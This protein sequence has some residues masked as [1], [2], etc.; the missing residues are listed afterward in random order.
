M[1]NK[2]K[3]AIA[4]ASA[5][6]FGALTTT[7]VLAEEKDPASEIEV[8]QVTGISS[9]LAKAIQQKRY[10]D[11]I[12]DS[13]VAEDLGKMP[14][15]NVAESLQRITGV[16]ISR[17]N[18]EG[19]KITI[20][21]FGPQFNVI[22]MNDRTLATTGGS[23][24]FDFQVLPSEMISGADVIKSPTA[25]L[26]SG[27]IGGYVNLHSARPLKNEGF[28]A[29]GSIKAVYQDLAE[30]IKPEISGIVSNTFADDTV[31]VLLGVSYKDTVSRLDTYK[32]NN[33][34]EYSN[35]NISG[36]DTWG[37]GFPLDKS[38]VLDENG[39]PTTLEG[40]RG[41]GRA[42]FTSGNEE[43]ERLG[44]NLALQWAPNDSMMST[45][46]MLYAKL[47]REQLGS[48]LQIAMQTPKYSAASVSDVG[49]LRTATLNNTDVEFLLDYSL[50]ES[51]TQA[52]G[53]NFSYNNE[54][55]TVKADFSYSKAK[56]SSEG[57]DSS[58]LHYTSFN[59]DGS[60]KKT[61]TTLDFTQ[62]DIPSLEINGMDVTDP[63]I[64]RAAWQRY[65]GYE[66]ED[67]IKEVKLDA[68]Y[69]FDEGVVSSIEVGVAY[70]NRNLASQA[71]GTEFDPVSGG[72]TWDGAG[73]WIG[74][75]STWGTDSNVGL[76]DT[77]IFSLNEGGYMKGV[78]GNFPRQWLT[79][80]SHQAYR[81]ASQN[82]L[83]SILSTD[84]YR[85]D[86]V[87]AGWDTTYKASGGLSSEESTKSAYIQ[88]NLGGDLGDYSWSGNIGGRYVSTTNK[89]SGTTTTI[90]LLK[91]QQL[92]P[93][94]NTA[95]ITTA[96][97]TAESSD[98]HFL[99]SANFSFE[100]DEGTYIRL[101]MAKNITRP[102]L[103]DSANNSGESPGFS[104]PTVSI[105]G[106]N[107]ELKPYKVQQLDLSFEH[108]GE[109]TSYA[110]GYFYKNI[111][112]FISQLTKI[113]T[114]E[115]SVDPALSN[116][117]AAEGINAITYTSNRKENREGGTIQGVE[118]GAMH[119]FDYLSGFWSGFGIQANYTWADSED[120]D[121]IEIDLPGIVQPS[122]ALEGFA[123]KSYNLVG[124][125]DKDGIGVRLAYNYRGD[126]M[127]SRS[128]QGYDTDYG[129]LDFSSSYDINDNV[130]V[131]F[132]ATNLTNET[133]VQYYGQRDR[134]TYVELSGVRYVLGVRASF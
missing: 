18:G 12:Q 116:A 75:G 128:V 130:A 129:Q 104:T 79:V 87:N 10:A 49:T 20:R 98:D 69:E 84:A 120:K 66:A 52:F 29:A 11:S 95:D 90:D 35:Y 92:N 115:G 125:Y 81:E 5:L 51:T 123:E 43:R 17:V 65:R 113:G 59:P 34:N 114:W 24:D 19:S 121:Q 67:E 15:Q 37:Y 105:W 100:I 14:D 31:G 70:S 6:T 2:S 7:S 76:I 112:N 57:D 122:N 94:K 96:P 97:T 4:I 91:L 62:G 109:H 38:K 53:Y 71:Y 132:E 133:R 32:A 9:G 127:N 86:I 47:D 45:F 99:P 101:G 54:N 77:S 63:S 85:A 55:L 27:S 61:S 28:H 119:T 44:V 68:Q 74:D 64:V 102:N 73:M 107:P 42:I 56:T 3:V 103:F 22:K 25:K 41:P 93:I 23:R 1:N 8:I 48:G 58:V 83:E 134:V 39:K 89:S 72:E 88:L 36:P 46:D 26:A 40:S 60:M 124:F 110:V 13:I 82:Y 111:T 50:E 106:G 80:T 117:Y 118:L 16:S 30:E 108:Y 21:G 131:S 126:F 33:W 78:G